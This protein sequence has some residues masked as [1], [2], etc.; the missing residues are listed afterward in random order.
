MA[1]HIDKMAAIIEQLRSMKTNH[2]ERLVFGILVVS[3]HPAELLSVTV[4]IKT[5]AD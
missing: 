1:L 3:I 5:L 2:D 4:S